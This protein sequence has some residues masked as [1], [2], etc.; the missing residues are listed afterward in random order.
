MAVS[1]FGY[2]IILRP[3]NSLSPEDGIK[4][5]AV[6][7]VI[8]L[9]VALVFTLMGAWL[10][11]PFAG[12]EVV[13]IAYA[14]NY[15][16]QHSGD[17]ESIAIEDDHVVVE[18]RN[19]KKFSATVY[20]RYWAQVNVRGVVNSSGLNGK[21]G[22]FIGSHGKEVEFGKYFIND[23]QRVILARELRQ[24]LRINY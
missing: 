20:Q 8:V 9:L 18:K 21:S 17:Y 13:A 1:D 16:H 19:Y 4:V 12:M 22:L 3:N 11:L 24:K 15:I 23:E 6:L 14:F 5:I 2:K 7:M 10:V